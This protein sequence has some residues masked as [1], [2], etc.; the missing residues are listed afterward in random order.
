MPEGKEAGNKY[1]QQRMEQYNTIVMKYVELCRNKEKKGDDL[2]NLGEEVG[3]YLGELA[4]LSVQYR[5]SKGLAKEAAKM[6]V[7][8]LIHSFSTHYPQF[9][10]DN[11][12]NAVMYPGK[13][14][15]ELAGLYIQKFNAISVE[16]YEIASEIKK[17]IQELESGTI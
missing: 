16:N 17:R 15:E 11:Y 3:A 13:I 10:L 12:K 6:K 4:N 7:D 14:G 8:K 1:I 9:D 5:Q 2:S